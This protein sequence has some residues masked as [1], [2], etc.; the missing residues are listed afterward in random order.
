[1]ET[2]A[3]KNSFTNRL[4]RKEFHKE[5]A[6]SFTSRS[7]VSSEIATDN[8]KLRL[9]IFFSGTSIFFAFNYSNNRNNMKIYSLLPLI[10]SAAAFT[11]S[12]HAPKHH[13]AVAGA[14]FASSIASEKLPGLPEGV[15][16]TPI[17][18]A[19][20]FEEVEGVMLPPNYFLTY[21]F[22]AAGPLIFG[23]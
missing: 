22:A 9:T 20:Y 12:I 5:Q 21:V 15:D 6:R 11:P 4:A 8:R 3:P 18:E 16:A 17:V 23:K 13:N 14:L 7:L 2:T 19:E 1:M 10:A